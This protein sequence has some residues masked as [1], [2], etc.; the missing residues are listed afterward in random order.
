MR[1]AR[2]A[3]A[4]SALLLA[5]AGCTDARDGA[6]E[7]VSELPRWSL[8]EDLR[9]DADAEDFSLVR[10][11]RVGANGW[12]AVSLPQESQVRLHDPE[13]RRAATIG[14]RGEGPGEFT[15]VGGLTW[16]ADTLVIEDV[17][18]RRYTWVGLDGAVLR[19]RTLPFPFEATAAEDA[20]GSDT[21]QLSIFVPLSAAPGGAVL[22]TGYIQSETRRAGGAPL[23]PVLVSL[24][25]DQSARVVLTPPDLFAERRMVTIDGLSNTVPFAN[26]PPPAFS[27]N[28]SR[29]AFVEADQSRTDGTFEVTLVR[30]DGDTVFHR[31]FP[32]EGHP[33]SRAAADSALSAMAERLGA[34]TEV[35][36]GRARR[37]VEL[38]GERIPAVHDPVEGLVAALDGTVW[39]TLREASGGRDALVLAPD[40]SPAARVLLPE[41]S[42]VQDA[43]ESHLYVTETDALGLVS[44]V[45]YRIVRPG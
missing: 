4:T 34:S 40:G 35:D 24:S 10:T 43:S 20:S 13:G 16:L 7:P 1:S 42:R 2:T 21:I 23:P 33:V 37:F 27:S 14:R 3:A 36:G 12:I 44:V 45:R 19:T 30:A 32:F 11:I 6:H 28:G 31:S 18:T 39:L 25:E 8:V 17:R 38:A 41:R 29:I 5:Q 9:L 15:L 22:G 26:R